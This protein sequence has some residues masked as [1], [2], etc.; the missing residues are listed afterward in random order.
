MP[1][2]NGIPFDGTSKIT[3]E[4]V[5]MTKKLQPLL[6][7]LLLLCAPLAT[8][9]NPDAAKRIAEQQTGGKVLSVRPAPSRPGYMVKVLL[10]DG[11]VRTI[12]VQP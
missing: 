1:V 4:S 10:S 7:G 5:T 6:A 12:Y 2:F 3:A 8:Q 9:A 11:R